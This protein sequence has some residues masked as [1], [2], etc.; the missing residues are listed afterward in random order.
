MFL[1]YFE[2][3]HKLLKFTSWSFGSYSLWFREGLK[4]NNWNF[5][6]GVLIP[7]LQ[8]EKNIFY[9]NVAYFIF[10]NILKQHSPPPIGKLPLTN[11][12]PL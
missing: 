11:P 8:L 9:K 4:K 7:P 12:L 6:I 3:G 10:R 1:Y 5:P 2:E